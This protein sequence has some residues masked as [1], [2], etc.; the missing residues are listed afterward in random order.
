MRARLL[1]L[2]SVVFSAGLLAAMLSSSLRAELP[3]MQLRQTVIRVPEG[4]LVETLMQS[5]GDAALARLL[6]QWV[7]KG[8]AQVVSDVSSRA[9]F[10]NKVDVKSGSS[11][12]WATEFKQEWPRPALTP[13]GWTMVPI[14]TGMEV[15]YARLQQLERPLLTLPWSASYSPCEPSPVRWPLVWPEN[16]KPEI[17]WFDQ[18]DFH[19]QRVRTVVP[20]FAGESVILGI[21]PPA[22]YEESE[23]PL[24]RGELDVILAHATPYGMVPPPAEPFAGKPELGTRITMVGIALKDVE[25]LKV[26]AGRDPHQ[27][28]ALL[29]Q[30]E[31]RVQTRNS[32]RRVL[33]SVSTI[34]GQRSGVESVREHYYPSEMHTIPSSWQ[35]RNVGTSLEMDAGASRDFNVAL[36][37]HPAPPRRATWKL[38]LDAPQLTMVQPQFFVQSLQT[39]AQFPS[40]VNTVLLGAMRTPECIAGGE[41]LVTGETL[42]LFAMR[43]GQENPAPPPADPDIV[44]EQRPGL[45]LEAIVFDLPLSEE[46]E[47]A[48]IDGRM[49]DEARYQKALAKVKDGSA[50]IAAHVALLTRVGQQSTVQTVEE[51]RSVTDCDPTWLEIPGR[52]RP[53]AVMTTP[54]G[55]VWEVDAMAEASQDPFAHGA[56]ELHLN[57]TLHHDV[58][59]A[60]QPTLEETLAFAR[61]NK[62]ELPPATFFT[63]EWKGEERLMPGKARCLG[64]LHP[65]GQARADRIHVA[66]V[67][68]R[69]DK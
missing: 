15:D 52:Y 2:T 13:I 69:L 22:G 32:T 12:K 61:A 31:L 42:L 29:K 51:T 57:H 60:K 9:A 21:M 3:A 28:E 5:P 58:L 17:G 7:E 63:N 19:S 59:P 56:L 65:A 53:T 49:D 46:A 40:G 11:Y 47:W 66:F 23:E 55:T 68:G 35:H 4:M 44:H 24:R 48:R 14:G 67:R 8:N 16:K 54:V 45:E 25:A 33:C 6:W 26:L 18:T 62:E 41:G 39:S 43:D 38:A 27:D 64:A 34:P 50:K 1:P 10:G 20:V 36:E 30:L 37:H